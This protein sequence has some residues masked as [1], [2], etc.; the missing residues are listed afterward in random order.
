M[1]LAALLGW[2]MMAVPG[3][4]HRGPLTPLSSEDAGLAAALKDH[5]TVIGAAEHNT[6]T[7]ARLEAVA[8]YLEAQ[9]HGQGHAVRVYPYDCGDGIVRNLEVV[10]AGREVGTIV[11]GA[12]YD[13]AI[14]ASGANDNGSG[15][16]ALLE[17]ARR[18]K[19]WGPRRTLR[20]AFFVNEEAPYFRSAGMGSRIYA[21]TLLARGETVVAM[22]SLETIGYYADAPRS[23]LYP[24]P[25]G[26][27]YPDRGDFLAFVANL[28]SRR[29]LHQTIA[30]FRTQARFP[31]EGVAAPVFVPGVDWSDQWSF[32]RHGVPAV[33]LTD[34]A[35]YRYPYYHLPEDTPDKVDYARLARV[36]AGLERTFRALDERI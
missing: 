29:L 26:L 8:A 32:W 7:P 30:A 15:V 16:A 6:R 3:T 27:F 12:H 31:S 25:L 4:S 28:A 2:Y 17:L 5:L 22:F 19:G 10:L 18:F 9:L 23:Q 13:S 36:V 20:L 1:A 35:L 14:G 21:D 34:T 33:M 11:I 24:F